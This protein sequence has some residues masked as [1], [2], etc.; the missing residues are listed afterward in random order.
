MGA[1]EWEGNDATTGSS[2]IAGKIDVITE[3]ATPEYSMRFFTQDNLSGTYEL[4]ERMRI[5]SDGKVGIGT[6]SPSATLE[7]ATSATT[8]IDVAHFSN[9]N[10]AVKA[11]FHLA[12][13]SGDGQLTLYDGNNNADVLISSVGNSYINSGGN[14]G[15]GTDSPARNFH[16]HASNF[17]DL[18]LTNDTTGAT[19]S[20]GTSFTAI[21]SDIYL[22][23]REAGNMVFQTSGTERARIDA[24]GNLAIGNVSAAAKLDIRQ[25]SGAAIRCEDGSGAYFVVK[26]GGTV[27]IGTPSPD[28]PLTVHNSSDPE[29]RFGYSSTQDHKIAW[30]SSKVFIHAD[31]ENANGSSAIGFA[32]DGSEKLARLLIVAV[33]Y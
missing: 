8:N 32:V 10:G 21:G 4:A 15:V 12:A 22:T 16:V 29:I 30:D 6:S 1:I 27:G 5:K 26:Q 14:V 9:S 3:D 11:K 2:G 17:T 23:N 24:S 31:P 7:I 20:D 28:A 33:I 13:T 18:H 19:A 25:D